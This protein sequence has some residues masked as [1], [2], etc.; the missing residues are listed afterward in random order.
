MKLC[1]GW[2]DYSLIAT[3]DGKKLE[4]FGEVTLLRPDPQVIW[5]APY[6]LE[7]V[8]K[9][10]AV[11]ERSETGGGYWRKIKNVPEEFSAEWQGLKFALKLMG[12]KHTGVFPEQAVN[13]KRI[14]E[15]VASANRPVKVLNLFGYTG[16]ASLAALSAGADVCHVD[17]AKAM[18]E[19]AGKNIRLSGLAP[20]CRFIVDDCVKFVER[21]IKRGSRYDAVIMD[22]PAFGRGP[23]G[24]TW[25]L[26]EKLFGLVEL[27]KSVM[28]DKP[29]F[30]LINSYT[31][32][33]LPSVMKNVVN[34]V[35]KDASPVVDADEIG[36]SGED[37][38]VL[39]CGASAFALFKAQP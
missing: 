18:C 13:W 9:P 29:L 26:E 24:E 30:Y 36:I 3:G 28:A 7:K 17:A 32:G 16:G 33:L 15:T 31:T 2:K 19:R 38:S 20:K 5:R 12:F 22:P 21:E 14:R 1:E 23:R 6:D 10:D 34:I 11:Y 27:T 25:R 8:G 35:F 37:G 39:P 4:R